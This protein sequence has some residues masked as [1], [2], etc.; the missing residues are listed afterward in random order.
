MELKTL[1]FGIVIGMALGS[2]TIIAGQQDANRP[3]IK[4]A[5]VPSEPIPAG[6]CTSSTF[7]YLELNGKRGDFT[8][9]EFGSMILPALRQ[10]YTLTIYPPTKR[11][12]FVNQ[13]C[14][15]AQQ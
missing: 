4:I 5:G 7:G 10:G 2:A 6:T 3:K 8:N 1:G 15:S 14:N 13:D 12:T 9:E 11:G